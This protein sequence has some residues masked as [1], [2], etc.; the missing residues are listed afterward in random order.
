MRPTLAKLSRDVAQLSASV[1]EP[2]PAAPE[3]TREELLALLVERLGPDRSHWPW[4]TAGEVDEFTSAVAEA[5][6]LAWPRRDAGEAPRPR[7]FG[8]SPGPECWPNLSDLT[9]LED[10]ELDAMQ[11]VTYRIAGLA[12]DRKRAG[13]PPDCPFGAVTA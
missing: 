4:L 9:W 8:T 3:M 12:Y 10:T 1:P 2:T 7:R 13:T 11:A 5:Y 6:M